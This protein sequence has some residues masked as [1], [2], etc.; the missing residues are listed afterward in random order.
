[1]YGVLNQLVDGPWKQ[2]L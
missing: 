1:M 2:C